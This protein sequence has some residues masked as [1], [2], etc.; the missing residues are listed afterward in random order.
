MSGFEWLSASAGSAGGASVL[1]VWAAGALAALLCFAGVHAFTRA[2]RTGRRSLPWRVALLLVGGGLMWVVTDSL[3]GRDRSTARSVL[4]ARMTELTLRAIAPGSPLACLDT[5][6]NETIEAGCEKTLFANPQTLAAAVAYAEARLNLLADA[7]EVVARDRSYE[8]SIERL[9]RSLEA[10]R[11]GMVAHVLAGRGCT[12]EQC[13]ALKLFR[14][15]KH[16]TAN[17]RERSFDA[18]VIIHAA[19]WGVPVVPS[20]PVA[21][22]TPPSAPAL[23][24]VPSAATTGVASPPSGKYDFPSSASIPAISIM[25]AEPPGQAGDNAPPPS[26]QNATPAAPAAK[27]APRRQ[28]A[29]ETPPPAQQPPQPQQ[30]GAMPAP[31]PP[32]GTIANP[33]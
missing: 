30:Q 22:T 16:V 28:T 20:V 5:V 4:E 17:L 10:D 9:R 25:S 33:R 1:P 11:F 19:T 13:L 32:P 27:P 24:A 14:D 29:R 3:G 8:P 6:A 15:P 26:Q 23:A 12:A 7:V 21:T 18:N 31:L 2:A